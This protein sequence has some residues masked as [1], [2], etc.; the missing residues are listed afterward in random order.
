VN[1]IAGFV[2]ILLAVVLFNN[3]RAGTL[4][5]W[6]RAKFLNDGG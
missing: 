2:L 4:A 3:F 1:T 5:L 6:L